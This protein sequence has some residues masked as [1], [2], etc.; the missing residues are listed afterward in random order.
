MKKLLLAAGLLIGF[1]TTSF[2]QYYQSPDDGEEA[3]PKKGF[4]K[5]KLFFGGS[6]GLGF[7]S[8]STLINISPQ[9]GYRFNKY[10]AAGAGVNFIYSSYK[11]EYNY[12]PYKDQY[13]VTGLNVF[14]RFYPIPYLFVQAQPE[15]NYT[16]GKYKSLDG[17][18]DDIKLPG[19]IVP[20]LLGGVGAAI[21]AGRGAFIVMIQND[22]IHDERSP[23]GT[24]SFF[25]FGYN[26]GF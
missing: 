23:Y 25:N 20:S 17:S 3:P 11:Y 15:A 10:F 18:F 12:P 21:P 26:I 2:S 8:V 22:L 7:G 14:G 13:G 19:K 6:F 16:W 5:S 4:D 24:R 1:A 9:V